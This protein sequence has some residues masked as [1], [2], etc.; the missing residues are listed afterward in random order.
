[1]K[2]WLR[3]AKNRSQ[4]RPARITHTRPLLCEVLETRL[5]PADVSAPAILQLY[6][7]TYRT[8]EHRAADLFLAG[9]GGIWTPPPGR[10][11]LGNLSVG[12]DVYDRFDLGGPGNST[13]YGSETGL[14]TL[15]QTI[16]NIGADYYLDYVPNHNG[17][18]NLA[19]VNFER[20]GG[21]P[22]FVLRNGGDPNG[23]FHAA[24]ETSETRR[25]LHGLIDIAQEKNH[26]YVRS[27]VPGFANNI[28][29]GTVA[30]YGRL[31]NIAQES[32]RRL[33]TD[34]DLTPLLLF[35]PTTG[36]QNIRSYPFNL[37]E[38]LAGD[39][40]A[41]NAM[42]LLMRNA[43]WLVQTIGIDGF[44][45]DAC[46]HVETSALNYLDRAVYRASPRPYLDGSTR[47]PFSFC[48][49]FDGSRP[50]LQNYIRK[51]INPG[52]PGRIGGNRDVLDFPFFFAVRDN[53]TNNGLTNDWR[54][55]VNASQD[56]F[57]DGRA[58][59]GSQGVAFER[60]HDQ[61]GAY[62]GN[63]AHAYMLMRPGNAIVYFN[64]KEFGTGRAFP[65]DGKVDALG[66]Y[67][68]NTITKLVNLRDSHGR[69]DYIQR[70][71]EKESL[72]FERDRSALV[73]LS[74]RLDG[75]YDSRTVLTNFAPGTRL[76]ELTGNAADPV[77]DPS[78]D[79]P[80]MLVVNADRTVNL[81]VPRNRAPGAGGQFH[82][83]GYF[84]Y[85]LAHPQGT[86]SLVNSARTIAG[87]TPTAATNGT[88]RLSPI[89]VVT[90]DWFQVQ[91]ETT[92]MVLLGAF[93]DRPGDGDNA[94]LRFD[95][96]RDVN[97]N[98]RVDLVQPGGVSYGFEQFVD[99]RSPGYFDPDGY[100]YYLQTIDASQLE[101]G[102]HFLEVRA[103]R[104]REAGPGSAIY[105]AFRKAIYVDRLPPDTAAVSFDPIQSGINENRRL[106]ARSLD[107]TANSVHVLFD[108]PA[109][110]TQEQV[111]AL[112]HSGN[113]A[114]QTDR[115]LF[116]RDARNLTHGNHV[117]TLVTY[118]MTGRYNIQ[119]FPGLFTSTILGRGLGD[120]N[121][122]GAV[123]P[124]DMQLFRQVLASENQQFNPA[125]DL[126]GDG[127]VDNADLLMLW[128]RL[129]EVG[130][131]EETVAAFLEILGPPPGGYTTLVGQSL[132]LTLAVPPVMTPPLT[133][134][135][136]LDADGFFG[137]ASG[138]E[139]TL[140]WSQLAQFGITG[141]GLYW[142]AVQASDGVSTADFW[143]NLVVAAE[144]NA[145]GPGGGGSSRIDPAVVSGLGSLPS[146]WSNSIDSGFAIVPPWVP[147]RES[148]P[149]T[150]AAFA[151]PPD[152]RFA[153][154]SSPP[155]ATLDEV[156]R[157]YEP[158]LGHSGDLLFADYSLFP[159]ERP[160]RLHGV[161]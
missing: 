14:R 150:A 19:T 110:L 62:L 105:R 85:G 126:N 39:P 21:Y 136:D 42:G 148:P 123:T 83:R 41:E 112:V 51:D 114:S 50:Y 116:S 63:V 94:L 102:M 27:P 16:H 1:M 43:K 67:Y 134:E 130:V 45:I 54:R 86:L 93:R 59:N 38:P 78:N 44:R 142:I 127:L 138:A 18:S 4:P 33:Y 155:S 80:E 129:W 117:A 3:L 144:G 10:A 60:S 99:A 72:I 46:K 24:S 55:V 159:R 28:P 48:E 20:A 37:A 81:R 132:T 91:L 100:G 151:N 137:D 95:D 32:N 119:R 120:L 49:N 141:E 69:G 135:W 152:S 124:T 73:V 149:D 84:I 160:K 89:D 61:A 97:G 71:L 68:G 139:V 74:N 29:P 36:E 76:I 113:R 92:P 96:G 147:A 157:L 65:R 88:A 154:L 70:L 11:D 15:V 40:V 5:A 128:Y 52:D 140:S 98:G 7:A 17:Y 153:L 26:Q 77:V 111:L 53:L 56:Q 108:L 143:T 25:R 47:H 133:Y 101:E 122:D 12:Y 131:S 35:D 31:A 125:A 9:Y 30:A 13:L 158:A 57:D 82:G 103:F 107:K 121:F 115:D 90:A 2:T 161:R 8:M 146:P 104:Q 75:G 79:F 6:E 58:N 156:F 106:V 109:E 34:R 66:G 64:A 22:G 87:E 23:D 145:P 118:E